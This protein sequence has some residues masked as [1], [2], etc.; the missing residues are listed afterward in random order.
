LRCNGC[1]RSHAADGRDYQTRHPLPL[2]EHTGFV[3]QDSHRSRAGT[4]ERL[5]AVKPA[6]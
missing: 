3:V 2:V 4:V 1:G 6:P 5:R